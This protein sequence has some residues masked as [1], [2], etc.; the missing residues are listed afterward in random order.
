MAQ[1]L[2]RR[3]EGRRLVILA[4]LG[5][6]TVLAVC[7]AI[8]FLQGMSEAQSA[9]RRFLAV[10][11]G[12]RGIQDDPRAFQP[13]VE[14]AILVGSSAMA[15][16][17]ARRIW[18]WQIG[19]AVGPLGLAT[20]GF[21]FSTLGAM[22]SSSILHPCIDDGTFYNCQVLVDGDRTALATLLLG[23]AAVLCGLTAV[24]T[25]Y[26]AVRLPTVHHPG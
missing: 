13:Y 20:V 26:L 3:A 22:W 19:W 10:G 2:D 9:F 18:Q 4:S 15:A 12:G 23:V 5:I 17:G 24:R 7:A 14:I 21:G 8:L 25:G 6:C 1:T 11:D 16:V